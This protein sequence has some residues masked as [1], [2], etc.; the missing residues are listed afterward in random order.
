[1]DSHFST[2][3]KKKLS[4]SFLVESIINGNGKAVDVD[5]GAVGVDANIGGS[6]SN[7]SSIP[8][9]QFTNPYWTYLM[10]LSTHRFPTTNYMPIQNFAFAPSDASSLDVVYQLGGNLSRVQLPV[11]VHEKSKPVKP[12]PTSKVVLSLNESNT[13]VP[14]R[15]RIDNNDFYVNGNFIHLF[16]FS[17]FFHIIFLN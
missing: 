16:F 4:K 2:C 1:M 6:K 5:H 7:L 10:G 17:F 12:I 8:Y 3:N 15:E 11:K 14:R 13:G 9:D